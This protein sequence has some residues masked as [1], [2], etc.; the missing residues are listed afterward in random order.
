M[1]N[2]FKMAI[3]NIGRNRRRSFM[4]A[5]ALA[6]GLTLLFF[7]AGVVEWE[8]KDS[9]ENTIRLQSGHLQVRNQNYNEDKTSLAWEDLIEAPQAVAAQVASLAPVQVATPRLYVSGIVAVGEQTAGVRI[10]GIDPA[11]AANAPFQDGLQSGAWLAADDREGIL[12]GKTLAEKLALNTGVT[13]PLLVNTS[14]GEVD[15]Q[16]FTIRGI[17]DTGIP[18]YD[19]SIVLLPLAKAQAIAQAGDHA[20]MI[21]V[22]LKDR[23]QTDAVVAAL[24]SG[25]YE[26]KTFT[27]L[28]PLFVQFDQLANSF[29]IILYLIVLAVTVTVIVNTLLM[30][31]FE[32]TREIGILAAIGMKSGGIMTMF[33][34]ESVILAVGGILFA[35]I[36]GA[37]LVNWLGGIGIPITNFGLTNF[38]LGERL[39]S[40]VTAKAI[41]N[42]S[43]LA[44]VV[45]LLGALYPARVAA[46]MEP[47]EALHAAQ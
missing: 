12:I 33:F 29:M 2:L 42:L 34:I 46:K 43:V 27:Q 8:M 25:Q 24:H 28:N 39:H 17:F 5:L 32:R 22:L 37:P 44:I 14:N 21:F 9:M 35:I 40:V 31:V 11:S 1:I 15:Q 23:A 20:S 7:M 36:A 6:L 13:A 10:L 16:N 30:S 4:S 41:L 19:E 3:R 47:V 45:T 26:T 38:L 18:T